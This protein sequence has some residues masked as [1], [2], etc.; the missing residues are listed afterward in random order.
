M[1]Y[2]CKIFSGSKR[3]G[4]E[5][6]LL[7]SGKPDGLSLEMIIMP[8]FVMG[9]NSSVALNGT[10]RSVIQSA[11]ACAPTSASTLLFASTNLIGKFASK[12]QV[13]L[14]SPSRIN[15]LLTRSQALKFNNLTSSEKSG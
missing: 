5:T 3:T 15:G 1:D 4:N 6:D 8:L 13:P 14:A 9:I 12:N 2:G 10:K 7:L 11:I